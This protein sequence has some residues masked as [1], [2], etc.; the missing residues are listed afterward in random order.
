MLQYPNETLLQLM[1]SMS[2]QFFDTAYVEN[3]L[4]HP[5]H[6]GADSLL[7]CLT[8]SDTPQP[9]RRDLHSGWTVQSCTY[10][11]TFWIWFAN[12]KGCQSH[13]PL[14]AGFLFPV[15]AEIPFVIFLL[16]W[17]G[18]KVEVV[19][20]QLWLRLLKI[21][22]FRLNASVLVTFALNKHSVETLARFSDLKV[23]IRSRDLMFPG[24][25]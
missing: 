1:Q 12:V 16:R 25:K 22:Q 21:L 11:Y 7:H 14:W 5:W 24:L 20:S 10:T 8:S 4:T 19:A 18:V 15:K 3:Q 13:L 6:L 17:K 2:D 9:G 23:G